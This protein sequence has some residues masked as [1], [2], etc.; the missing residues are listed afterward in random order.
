MNNITALL[1]I[2][3]IISTYINLGYCFLLLIFRTIG[4]GKIVRLIVFNKYLPPDDDD[5]EYDKSIIFSL[6]ITWP[7]WSSLLILKYTW[8]I[9]CYLYQKMERPSKQKRPLKPE[10]KIHD[11]IDNYTS[12]HKKTIDIIHS[13]K[14]KKQVEALRKILQDNIK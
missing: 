8:Q 3:F 6:A 1:I 10:T 4:A 9:I 11:A 7:I 12:T 14:A 5:I 2:I 13:S